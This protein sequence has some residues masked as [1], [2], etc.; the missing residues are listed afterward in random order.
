MAT[1]LFFIPTAW[2]NHCRFLSEVWYKLIYF[3]EMSL[4][5]GAKWKKGND[6]RLLT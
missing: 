2:E 6:S 5:E 4:C 3:F 1:G